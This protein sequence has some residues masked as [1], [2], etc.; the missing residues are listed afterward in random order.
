MTPRL[1]E[2]LAA[3]FASLRRLGIVRRQAYSDLLRETLEAH[4][5]LL[6]AWSVWEPDSFDGRDAEF[7]FAPGHDGTGRFVPYWHRAYGSPK[8]DPVLGYEH[9]GRGDWYWVPKLRQ[10]VC[11]VDDYWYS[12][13]DRLLCIRSEIVPLLESG[14]CVGAV[15]LDELAPN[16]GAGSARRTLPVVRSLEDPT[17]LR[18]LT[19]RE[20]EIHHWLVEGKSNEEIALILGISAHTVKNH[21]SHIFEKL[22]V[23]NRTA[24][25]LAAR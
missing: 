18:H 8:L 10:T 12:V 19:R 3:A 23:E 24:A 17:P 22:G 1:V 2:S 13:G 6:G 15:G 11:Q 25:A 4:P 14:R 9:P 7:Q 16:P 21:L 20:R 5:D